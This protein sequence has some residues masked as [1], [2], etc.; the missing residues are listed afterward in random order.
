LQSLSERDFGAPVPASLNQVESKLEQ[1]VKLV[2]NAVSYQDIQQPKSGFLQT[3][4]K[5]S[6]HLWSI[7]GAF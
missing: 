3:S 2:K 6:D 5:L 7:L 1:L 4:P